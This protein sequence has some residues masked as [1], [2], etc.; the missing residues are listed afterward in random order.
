M[1][2]NNVRFQRGDIMALPYVNESYDCVTGGYAL[3]NVPVSEPSAPE[4]VV[5][6]GGEW[7][8][9]EFAPG[10]GVSSLGLEDKVPAP[11]STEEKGSILDIFRR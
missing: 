4:G 5:S 10:A 7:F 11:S 6:H 2:A 1:G 8:F 3:R 9:E